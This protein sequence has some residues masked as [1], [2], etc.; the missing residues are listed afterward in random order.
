SNIQSKHSKVNV[1]SN[2]SRPNGATEDNNNRYPQ[3]SKVSFDYAMPMSVFDENDKVIMIKL[4]DIDELFE[5]M[6]DSGAEFSAISEEIVT[7]F[8]LK[9]TPPV[10]PK[11]LRLADKKSFVDRRGTCKMIADILFPGDENREVITIKKTF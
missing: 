4:Q 9:I 5:V 11:R 8:N 10:G 6:I 1:N 3:L 7:R 2:I